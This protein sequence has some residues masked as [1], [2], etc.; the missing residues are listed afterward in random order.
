VVNIAKKQKD[1]KKQSSFKRMQY[2][3]YD[4]LKLIASLVLFSSYNAS[5][6]IKLWN[7]LIP[8]GYFADCYNA[9]SLILVSGLT[10]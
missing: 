2:S 7:L 1:V 5:G 8:A 3:F 6:S 4:F 9:F 10:H